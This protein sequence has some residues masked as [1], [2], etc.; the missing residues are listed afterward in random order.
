M[1]LLA[2]SF[3]AGVLTVLA[4]CILPLLPVVIGTSATRRSTWTPYIV[5][6]SLALSIILF[7]YLLKFSTALIMVPPE[8]WKYLSGGILFLFGLVLIFPALWEN[9]P[10]IARL[11]ISSNKLIG[12]GYQKKSFWGDVIIGAALGPVFSSCSPTYFVILASVLPASFALGSLYLFTYAAGLSL[13]LLL[14]ALLGQRFADRLLVAADSRGL[15]KRSVGIIF[16]A[17]ALF[18]MTGYDKKVQV[19]ILES[20]FVD[21]VKWEQNILQRFQI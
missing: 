9:V 1:T 7:T 4:P 11:S 5:V 18:V 20:G 21:S 6:G 15:F 12:T 14:I 10:G 16:I 19:W 3:I 17:V 8:F 2:I 13:A